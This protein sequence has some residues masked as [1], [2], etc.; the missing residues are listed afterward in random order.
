MRHVGPA[1]KRFAGSCSEGADWGLVSGGWRPDDAGVRP[2][3]VIPD[4]DT[5]VPTSGSAVLPD[6]PRAN[7]R[8]GLTTPEDAPFGLQDAVF[9]YSNSKQAYALAVIEIG[10]LV[11]ARL[12]ERD[13]GTVVDLPAFGSASFFAISVDDITRFEIVPDRDFFGPVWFTFRLQ[14]EGGAT[15]AR[16]GIIIDVVQRHDDPPLLA[17]SAP[18]GVDENNPAIGQIAGG[19]KPELG[20]SL[21]Y[22]IDGPNAYNLVLSPDGV[23]TRPYGFDF[24]S[25]SADDI[26]GALLH[27]L[28]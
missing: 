26:R 22:H 5:A 8:S 25:L 28:L 9:G 17:P 19:S 23:L 21:S 18:L 2:H 1:F 20:A 14:S 24:E 4:G 6:Q 13:S 10:G 16:T 7:P 3:P 11:N 12:R 15:T 27:T